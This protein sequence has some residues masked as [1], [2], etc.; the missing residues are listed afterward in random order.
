M[1]LRP[2]TAELLTQRLLYGTLLLVVCALGGA[3]DVLN[4]ALNPR[5]VRTAA[6]PEEEEPTGK[7]AT[8]FASSSSHNRRPGGV[9]RILASGRHGQPA[10]A[11]VHGHTFAPPS[12]DL[13][14]QART[15]TGAGI[16]LHC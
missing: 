4:T 8:A 5:A 10:V 14:S 11:R 16:F 1:K 6:L 15:L 2:Q 7:Q 3:V 13:P 9:R 12:A